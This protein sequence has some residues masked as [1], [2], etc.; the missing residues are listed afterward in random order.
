MHYLIKV[1]AIAILLLIVG[2][3]GVADMSSNGISKQEFNE[4][5]EN[6]LDYLVK[7]CIKGTAVNLYPNLHSTIVNELVEKIIDDWGNNENTGWLAFQD[8]KAIG[9]LQAVAY[10][11]GSREDLL[12]IYE[13]YIEKCIDMGKKYPFRILPPSSSKVWD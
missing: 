2:C 3:T 12:S 1:L 6:R 4:I 7:P 5:Q 9:A 8:G 13:L 10:L 11:D